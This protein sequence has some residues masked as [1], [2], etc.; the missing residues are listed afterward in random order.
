MFCKLLYSV[1]I[2]VCVCARPIQLFICPT[3]MPM[4][5]QQPIDEL[6][7]GLVDKGL[8]QQVNVILVLQSVATFDDSLTHNTVNHET[9]HGHMLLSTGLWKNHNLQL[10]ELMWHLVL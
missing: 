6:S 8:R 5:Q 9:L 10:Y 4:Q 1:Y 2:Y 7:A 3:I